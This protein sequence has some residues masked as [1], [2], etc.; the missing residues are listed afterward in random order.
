[1]NVEV[2]L[3]NA[4]AIPRQIFIIGYIKRTLSSSLS[5]K[6]GSS[7]SNS[8]YFNPSIFHLPKCVYYPQKIRKIHQ[9]NLVSRSKIG[10][11]FNKNVKRKTQVTRVNIVR[12]LM[13]NRR[14]IFDPTLP[15]TMRKTQK[16][17]ER[18][19]VCGTY[20]TTLVRAA[21]IATYTQ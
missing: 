6:W 1:M 14:R 8:R 7:K 20:T 15:M 9:A 21:V 12:S 3:E 19:K 10:T 17:K 2:T 13:R 18:M 16:R 4:A 11:Y 5:K